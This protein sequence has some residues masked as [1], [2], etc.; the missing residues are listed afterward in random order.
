MQQ[1]GQ[2]KARARR[3]KKSIV[4][5]A[6][7]YLCQLAV[8][9]LM[10]DTPDDIFGAVYVL[11]PVSAGGVFVERRAR[12]MD[13]LSFLSRSLPVHFMGVSLSTSACKK[14]YSLF[15]AVFTFAAAKVEFTIVFIK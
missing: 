14:L 10:G 5:L 12:M 3:E 11:N 2:A 6:L 7:T 13:K 15:Q 1:S 8:N 4:L 9:A